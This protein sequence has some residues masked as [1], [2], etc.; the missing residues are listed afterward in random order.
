MLEVRLLLQ[1]C[2]FEQFKI[3]GAA[4]SQF[5]SLFSQSLLDIQGSVP[6]SIQQNAQLIIPVI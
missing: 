1:A 4:F 5:T 2:L 6:G 3:Q